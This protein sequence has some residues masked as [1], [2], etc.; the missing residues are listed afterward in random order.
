MT[1]RRASDHE[2]AGRAVASSPPI[3]LNDTGLGGTTR[4][5][6]IH[7]GST[8]DH[9]IKRIRRSQACWPVLTDHAMSYNSMSLSHLSCRPHPKFFFPP[10]NRRFLLSS[11][12]MRCRSVLGTRMRCR[13]VVD[14]SIPMLSL[15]HSIEA[16]YNIPSNI[17]YELAA[18]RFNDQ[19]LYNIIVAQI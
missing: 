11:C 19:Y 18:I 13:H 2:P 17:A 3:N 8:V 5:S 4:R 6:K 7:I 10:S 9:N 12:E 1:C 15:E 16:P 14:I